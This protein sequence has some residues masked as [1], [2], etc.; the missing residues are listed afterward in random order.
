M[1]CRM[2]LMTRI[3]CNSN[4]NHISRGGAAGAENYNCFG[5]SGRDLSATLPKNE[6][7][8]EIVLTEAESASRA[9]HPAFSAPSAK[10][11]VASFGTPRE[12]ASHAFASSR[13]VHEFR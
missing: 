6:G 2:T 9:D 12:A 10:I 1:H 7:S 8:L 11:R 5:S 13:I 4:G 3:Y